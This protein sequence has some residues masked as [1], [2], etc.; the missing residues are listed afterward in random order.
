[1]EIETTGNL[2]VQ[3]QPKLSNKQTLMPPPTA[4]TSSP[5][6]FAAPPTG[7]ELRSPRGQAEMRGN[8]PMGILNS[9]MDDAI[10]RTVSAKVLCTTAKTNLSFSPVEEV[11][12]LLVACPPLQRE[13]KMNFAALNEWTSFYPT[14]ASLET[15]I[16]K[17]MPGFLR[18]VWKATL[19][20]SS[21]G[22]CSGKSKQH[23]TNQHLHSLDH[24]Q[25]DKRFSAKLF[26]K[27]EELRAIA[28]M[29][30]TLNAQMAHECFCL[31]PS[32]TTE[33]KVNTPLRKETRTAPF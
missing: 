11:L 17:E 16:Y 2:K 26:G 10:T 32:E 25:L 28:N 22:K 15:V 27:N 31:E 3:L 4:A 1:M 5:N 30:V 20:S 19:K 6:S 29:K 18:I 14:A 8:I 33:S 13:K 9:A 7:S 21:F 24:L 12:P 23:A